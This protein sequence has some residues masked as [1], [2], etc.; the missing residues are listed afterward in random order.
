MDAEALVDEVLQIQVTGFGKKWDGRG[1]Q[2]RLGK[3]PLEA[4]ACLIE[5]YGLPCT[6][7]ELTTET[8][9]L[10]QPR[11]F[12]KIPSFIEWILSKGWIDVFFMELLCGGL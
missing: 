10:L 6:P 12:I 1:A 7:E 8:L 2:K 4:A 5:D 11:L 9:A 3:R